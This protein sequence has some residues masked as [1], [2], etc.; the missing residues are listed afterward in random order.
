MASNFARFA[1]CKTDESIIEA[2]VRLLRDGSRYHV[3]FC[4]MGHEDLIW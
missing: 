1:F 3:G 2:E 4:S